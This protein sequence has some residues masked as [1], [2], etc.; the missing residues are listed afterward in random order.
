MA[1]RGLYRAADGSWRQ[2]D[3]STGIRLLYRLKDRERWT[4]L[5]RDRVL[6]VHPD[7]PPKVVY[8]DGRVEGIAASGRAN[9]ISAKMTTSRGDPP[10]AR[11]PEQST[12]T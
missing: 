12:A 11:E 2:A 6:V 10:K 7:R 1:A 5:D 9:A 4:L 8:P 3:A